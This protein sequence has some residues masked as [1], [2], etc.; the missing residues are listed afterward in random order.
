LDEETILESVSNTGRLVIV[1]ESHPRCNVAADIAEIAAQKAFGD[2]KAP[3][4]MVDQTAG[5]SPKARGICGR[6]RL[7]ECMPKDQAGK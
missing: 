4:S 2:L 3:V 6:P 1:D 7:P 5:R